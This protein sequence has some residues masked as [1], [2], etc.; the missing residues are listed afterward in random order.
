MKGRFY[1]GLVLALGLSIGVFAL[2]GRYIPRRCEGCGG[3]TRYI[4][5]HT[6]VAVDAKVSPLDLVLNHYN[7]IDVWHVGCLNEAIEKGEL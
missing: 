4:P 5:D 7:D 2:C 1:G 3:V 6:N